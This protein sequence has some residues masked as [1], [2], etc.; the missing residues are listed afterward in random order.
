MSL[1]ISVG[2]T[3]QFFSQLVRFGAISI[4]GILLGLEAL[5]R[6]ARPFSSLDVSECPLFA[7]E[8]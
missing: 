6:L 7:C 1:V 4:D 2:L 5:Y 3:H 8:G